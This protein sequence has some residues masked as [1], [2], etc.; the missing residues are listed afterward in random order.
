MNLTK[1]TKVINVQF[2]GFIDRKNV[3]HK[4]KIEL[5]SFEEVWCAATSKNIIFFFHS[6]KHQNLWLKIRLDNNQILYLY[7]SIV[8]TNRC[9]DWNYRCF[10]DINFSMDYV[11][12]VSIQDIHLLMCITTELQAKR[13]A[14]QYTFN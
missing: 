4:L 9:C 12:I 1:K 7:T 3:N 13:Q 11:S 14:L 5:L 10:C 2:I 6:R 8:C